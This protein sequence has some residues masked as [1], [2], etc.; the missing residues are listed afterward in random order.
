[1]PVWVS[2]VPRGNAREP[3]ELNKSV[4]RN[5]ARQ[6]PILYLEFN[7]NSDDYTNKERWVIIN[8][9]KYLRH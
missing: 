2:K 6:N 9:K 1:M 5:A 7:L 3:W 8:R 4:S